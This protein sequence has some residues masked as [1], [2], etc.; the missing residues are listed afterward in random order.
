MPSFYN[1]EMELAAVKKELG[2]GVFGYVTG[3]RRLGKTALLLKACKLYGGIYHQAVEGTPP[4]QIEY[5]TSELKDHFSIFKDIHPKSWHEFFNLLS[6]ERLP[7]L[8]VFDEF[9][10]WV[11]SDAS[12]PSVLQKW[13]DHSLSKQKTLLLVSGSS[14]TMLYSQFLQHSSPL[15]GRSKLHVHLQPMSYQWFCRALNY[16]PGDDLSFSRFSLVGG[17]PHYW[18][19]LQKSGFMDQVQSLY[20]KPV[21]PLSEEPKHLLAE[22]FITGNLP[23]SLLDLVGRGVT[24]PGEMASRLETP[25]GNLSR[26]LSLLLELGLLHRELPFG[27]SLRTSKK[28]LYTIKD[29]PLAFYYGTYMPHRTRWPVL[30]E[31]EKKVLV[32]QHVSRQ[33]ENYCRLAHPGSSRYWEA[34][35]EIDVIAP[36]AQGKYLV[37]ECKWTNLTEKREKEVLQ[38]LENK[39]LKTQLS[40]KLKKVEFSVFSKKDILRLARKES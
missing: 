18:D 25:Q 24:K 14:Q 22:E 39:F 15:Y 23:K 20:F 12:L 10:Y 3:R 19:F 35:V 5:L 27:E 7:Q 16:N 33:W 4:Q 40:R 29:S 28:V 31:K 36:V 6:R 2:K 30:S 38:T 26:P 34:D 37:A 9:P 13:I 17:I 32:D 1:R 21:A 11:A 8:L